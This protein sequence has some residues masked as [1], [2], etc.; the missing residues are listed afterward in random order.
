MQFILVSTVAPILIFLLLPRFLN[1]RKSYRWLLLLACI[2]FMVSWLLPSPKVDGMQTEFVTHF[3]GGGVFTGLL[4]LYIKLVKRWRAAWWIEAVSLYALVSS[5]GVLNELF[6]F[7]LY[8]LELMPNG[9]FDTSW[10]LVANT[11]G[12]MV[13]YLGYKIGR[14]WRLRSDSMK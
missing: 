5:L 12:A 10:D 1:D 9:I 7:G 13:F 14:R 2:V 3:V 6:E 4:W 8:H 11:S